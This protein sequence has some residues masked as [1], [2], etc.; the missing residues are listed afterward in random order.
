ML[1]H[2]FDPQE[3]LQLNN[4]FWPGDKFE[5]LNFDYKEENRKKN[6]IN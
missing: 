6:I 2:K 5:N 1:D 4:K 3:A